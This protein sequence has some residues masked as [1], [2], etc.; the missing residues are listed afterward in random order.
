[1]KNMTIKNKLIG[2]TML[3]SVIS[4]LLA[5]AAF[6]AWERNI[7]RENM[8][9]DLSMLAEMIAE[10]S[11]A[12]IAFED[13]QDAER[14]LRAFHVR[15]DI[16]VA[17][18]STMNGEILAGYQIDPASHTGRLIE[19]KC[20]ELDFKGRDF[21]FSGD[22]LAV[23]KP[24]VLDGETIG[25]VCLVSDLAP[26]RARLKK[27]AKI[28][29]AF[30]A[31]CSLVAFLIS[32]RLQRVI[33][34]PI[35]N[36][37]DVAKTVSEKE[38][39]STRATKHGNDEVGLLIDSFNEMLGQIQRRDRELVQAKEHLETRVRQRTTELSSTNT[40]LE[41]EISV[42]KQIEVK[43]REILTKLENAN[44]DL[45]DFAYIVSHDLK[46]P[47]RGIKT[48]TDW[49]SAD[50]A[51]KI[52]ENGREQMNL[53]S[54]R[55]DR[56]HNLIEGILQYSRVG[57][58]KEKLAR[59]DLNEIVPEIID[60]IAPP[61]NISITIENELP[62][63]ICEPTRI[64]QVFQN[65]LSNAVKYM[66]KPQGIIRVGCV[67]ENG[68]WKFNVADNGPG[69][70]EKYFE[71]VFQM[72]QTLSPR[73]EF[74]S[75]GVG[76]TVI[77]KIVEMYGGKIWIE[78]EPGKGSNFIFTFLKQETEVLHAKHQTNTAG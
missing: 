1:M 63:I 25:K 43:Q 69:I 33:S 53:V 16:D 55:V 30:L 20:E 42:R 38:D 17:S 23:V 78:S 57:R 71:K 32:S 44:K 40:K 62:E 73:D 39:Y 49:I 11:A 52:D 29:A 77:K 67:E 65:L 47:L 5:G 18:I 58:I 4:L 2:I 34:V 50:Y 14:I 15:P 36:L 54:N 72:F 64:T 8:V 12:A 31:L 48:L 24:V 46:A 59:V 27:H 74:E 6:M 13:E 66:D 70:E 68:Y 56:M 51:D 76:L 7:L 37:A 9:Q 45:S 3:T 75:T 35:L 61:P 41:G 21:V 10:N 60:L 28:I 26:L 22:H 19:C